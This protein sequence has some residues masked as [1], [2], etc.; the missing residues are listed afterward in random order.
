M[1]LEQDDETDWLLVE[2]V[3]RERFSHI[4]LMDPESVLPGEVIVFGPEDVEPDCAAFMFL[5]NV[6]GAIFLLPALAVWLGVGQ[7]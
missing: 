7:S 6:L 3:H 2:Q 1:S 4:E 5:V